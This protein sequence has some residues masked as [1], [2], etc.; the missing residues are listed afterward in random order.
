MVITVVSTIYIL[1][2]RMVWYSMAYDMMILCSLE[3]LVLGVFFS[4]YIFFPEQ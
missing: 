2:V 4:M 1:Q 3:K